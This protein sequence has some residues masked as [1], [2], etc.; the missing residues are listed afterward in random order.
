MNKLDELV[1]NGEIK[2]YVY[3]QQVPSCEGDT[4]FRLIDELILTFPKGGTLN[5]STICSGVLEN[6]S[7]VIL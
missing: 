7:L 1:A 3:R 4:K 5:L 2:S 6:T